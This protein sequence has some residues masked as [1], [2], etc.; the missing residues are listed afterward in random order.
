M[1]RVTRMEPYT[2]KMMRLE[3]CER[4]F[5]ECARYNVSRL[6]QI[7]EMDVPDEI[8]PSDDAESKEWMDDFGKGYRR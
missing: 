4:N 6:L 8:W 2:A 1:E 7:P 5:H 3:Y